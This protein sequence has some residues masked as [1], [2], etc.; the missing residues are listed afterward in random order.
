MPAFRSTTPLER[1]ILRHALPAYGAPVVARMISDLSGQP[2]TAQWVYN[3]AAR[4][5]IERPSLAERN[6]LRANPLGKI[7]PEVREAGSLHATGVR[8]AD[9][10]ARLGIP[11]GTARRRIRH[12]YRAL[13]VEDWG[14][15]GEGPKPR[16][17]PA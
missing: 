7:R 2:V 8:T 5:G 4:L 3:R 12:Y 10:A 14:R 15:Q 9:V 16:L 1:D 6:R 13:G 17:A 11:Y